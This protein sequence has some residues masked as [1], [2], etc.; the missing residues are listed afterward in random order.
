VDGDELNPLTARYALAL[1]GLTGAH[2]DR[3]VER[4]RG[5]TAFEAERAVTHVAR[6]PSPPH[7]SPDRGAQILILA[8]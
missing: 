8:R 5:F 7:T 4:L 3:R 6:H 1:P 2:L